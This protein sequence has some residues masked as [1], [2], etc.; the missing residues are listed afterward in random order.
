MYVIIV[1]TFIMADHETTCFYGSIMVTD[2]DE[3]T[4]KITNKLEYLYLATALS[5]EVCQVIN[6]FEFTNAVELAVSEA[7]T[8]AIKHSGISDSKK[9]IFI[10]FQ[11]YQD[12]LVINVKDQGRGFD[13]DTV[14]KPDLENHPEGGYGIFIIKSSM[15]EVEYRRK[16]DYNTLSMT[17]Y[18]RK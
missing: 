5:R 18:F 6:D 1:I 9:N 17:K 2:V 8:N 14:M 12:R 10:I 4:L 3:I 13:I 7:V 16:G 11:I 15:D